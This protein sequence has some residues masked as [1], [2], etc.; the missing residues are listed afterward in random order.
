[1]IF[2]QCIANTKH[3]IWLDNLKMILEVSDSQVPKHRMCT[4]QKNMLC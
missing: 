3:I 1:M 4:L 2:F